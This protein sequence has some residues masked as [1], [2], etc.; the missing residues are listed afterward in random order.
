MARLDSLVGRSE[1]VGLDS[2]ADSV[3]ADEL[4]GGRHVIHD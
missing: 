2:G 3:L 1:M 4:G